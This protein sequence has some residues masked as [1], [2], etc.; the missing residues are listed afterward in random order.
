MVSANTAGDTPGTSGAPAAPGVINAGALD[1]VA[2]C[3]RRLGLRYDAWR[4]LRKAGLERSIVRIG[5]HH[6]ILG[7][8]VLAFFRGQRGQP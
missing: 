7:E 2:E 1:T 4:T 6:F 3:Q 8:D 5:G